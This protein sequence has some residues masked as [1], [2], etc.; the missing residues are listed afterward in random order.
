MP[1][2]F[3]SHVR[4]CLQRACT[5]RN[6]YVYYVIISIISIII[7]IISIPTR[8]PLLLRFFA[9]VLFLSKYF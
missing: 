5:Q 2:I 6:V 4:I 8:H 9:L 1:V 7:R 3:F